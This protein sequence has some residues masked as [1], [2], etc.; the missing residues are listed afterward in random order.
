[1]ENPKKSIF[2]KKW[3]QSLAGIFVII[4][5]VGGI[6]IYKS[7]S[8]YVSIDSGEILA[9]VI[10]IGPEVSGVLDE[11]YVKVGDNVTAG[12]PLAHI[13]AEVLTSKIDGLIISV[14]NTPGQLFVPTQAV[15]KIINPTELRLIGTIKEDAGL[16]KIKIGNPVTFTLDAFKGQE[17]TGVVDE[18]SETSKDSSIV[19][20]ISDKREVKDFTIKI[21][22]N[23]ELNKEFKNGMSAKIKVYYK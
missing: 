7:I 3:V 19:F 21:K 5:I 16:S 8:S 6:L 20:S 10:N 9:P 1:M 2:A 15:I 14:T 23:E 22:Y 12:Q 4:V 17:Y 18:V 11:V 13:G